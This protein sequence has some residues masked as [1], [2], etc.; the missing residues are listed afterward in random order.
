MQSVNA[1]TMTLHANDTHC[2]DLTIATTSVMCAHFHNKIHNDA[3]SDNNILIR[4]LSAASHHT[5]RLHL[6]HVY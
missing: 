6:D 4:L 3:H 5:F 2:A 1:K